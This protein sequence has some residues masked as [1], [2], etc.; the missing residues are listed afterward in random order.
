MGMRIMDA[1]DR[2]R[3]L[4]ERILHVLRQFPTDVQEALIREW[5]C[6]LEAGFPSEADA[7]APTDPETDPPT[8]DK[9]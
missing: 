2:R 9:R 5:Q 6:E 8:P 7:P 4:L 3:E 1:P